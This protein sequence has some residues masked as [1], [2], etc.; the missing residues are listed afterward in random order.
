MTLFETV[1]DL[2][3]AVESSDRTRTER[4]TSSGFTRATTVY[5]LSGGDETGRG[6]D[7]T[8][9]TE[10]H[11]ALAD[12]P[13]LVGNDDGQVAPGEYTFAEFSAALD[14]VD[15]FPAREPERDTA[16]HYRRW[17]VESA[18]LDLALRQAGTNLG[19]VVDRNYDPVR[20]VVSTRLGD[21]PTTE[22]VDAL[23]GRYPETELKLDPTAEWTEDVVA[24]LAETS[25]VRILDLKGRYEGTEV[26]QAP[27]PALY[28]LVFENF[29][30]A[31]VEDPGQSAATDP[32]VE[33]NAD[34]ISWDYPITGVESVESLPF[35]PEWLNVKPSRFGT[36]E[37]L[38][39]TLDYA[40]ENGISLYGGGQF[41]LG[42]GR[43][44]IQALAS[45]FYADGPNDV[46]P[47]VY[48]DPEVPD[49]AP[50]SP[51]SPSRSPDGLGF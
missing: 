49:D 33:D 29:P 5:A 31:V 14:D 37:S 15:L 4:D 50:T 45:L 42:V 30:D 1:S 41:E 51:L 9:D 44:Q 38:F 20:F 12:A 6:E 28:E 36:V 39:D 46:A 2:T 40:A 47:G 8:Y 17:A 24:D 27:D 26:D 43:D 23:L 3:L 19:D 25:A 7:V 35:E 10:D 34:R 16:R 21:P 22:R 11:D 32:L 13:A 18:G 48:N